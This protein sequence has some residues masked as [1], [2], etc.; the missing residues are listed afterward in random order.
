MR[1]VREWEQLDRSTFTTGMCVILAYPVGILNMKPNRTHVADVTQMVYFVLRSSGLAALLSPMQ[2]SGSFLHASAQ[3]TM[4]NVEYTQLVGLFLAC[5]AHDLDHRGH[6]I[7]YERNVGS[8]IGVLPEVLNYYCAHPVY[9]AGVAHPDTPL[10]QH[11]TNK[12]MEIVD[13]TD[14]F[15][16]LSLPSQDVTKEVIRQC[17]MCTEMAQHSEIMKKFDSCVEGGL[18]NTN[19]A[20]YGRI[21]L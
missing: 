9:M 16:N 5:P 21:D 4:H 12:A 3:L 1:A 15:S 10:E 7:R 6:T 13:A 14:I 8:D 18:Q 17:I 11:H 20:E 2:V 19:T